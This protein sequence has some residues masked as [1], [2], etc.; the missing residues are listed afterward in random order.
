MDTRK[1]DDVDDNVAPPMPVDRVLPGVLPGAVD[2]T[3]QLSGAACARLVLCARSAL[4]LARGAGA[5]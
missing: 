3:A 1:N 4:P 2:D 5:R